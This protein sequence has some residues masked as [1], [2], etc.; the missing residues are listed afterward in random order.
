MD[1]RKTAQEISVLQ[2]GEP[3]LLQQVLILR[4]LL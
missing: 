3:M 1:Y 2:S 4:G